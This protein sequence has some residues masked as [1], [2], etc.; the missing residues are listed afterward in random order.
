MKN[1]HRETASRLERLPN[2][3]KAIAGH[4]RSIGID[5][6]RKLIGKDPF[7]LYEA[8][9]RTSGKRIDPCVMDVCMS[10]VHFMQGD[11]PLPWW[12]FTDER[13]RRIIKRQKGESTG[14]SDTRFG[15]QGDEET[16]V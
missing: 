2:V 1:P 7:E 13:K 15:L 8:L 12:S 4:L 9:C 14:N 10:V 6:P 5:H 3:G 16:T 11:D